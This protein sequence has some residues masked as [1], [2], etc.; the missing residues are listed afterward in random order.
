MP[1]LTVRIDEELDAEL[2]ELA[3][4]QHRSK[5]ELVR[6][7]LRRQLALVAFKEARRELVPLGEQ[8]GLITDEDVF[9]LMS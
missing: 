4:R 7:M 8:A 1:T 2:T 5:S 9:E 3:R 6:Q